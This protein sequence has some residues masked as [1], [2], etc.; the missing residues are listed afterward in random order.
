MLATKEALLAVFVLATMGVVG[1][2]HGD[3]GRSAAP[4]ART[5]KFRDALLEQGN[6]ETASFFSDALPVVLKKAGLVTISNGHAI[7]TNEYDIDIVCYAAQLQSH[8]VWEFALFSGILPPKHS[9]HLQVPP[10][11][12]F[13]S[14]SHDMIL[15][16]AVEF[17]HPHRVIYDIKRWP[18][19]APACL[20]M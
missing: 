7:L 1:C 16:I 13:Q 6:R 14:T 10:G 3:S 8:G 5:D 15:P 19:G 18:R 2:S 4:Q 12:T 11:V 9:A 20:T 17:Q